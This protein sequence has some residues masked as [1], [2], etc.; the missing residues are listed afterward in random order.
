MKDKVLVLGSSGLIGHQVHS[1]LKKSGEYEL[2]DISCRNKIQDNTILLN[3]RDEQVFIDKITNIHPNYII[4]CIGILINASN[5]KP[6]DSIFLNAYMPHV[7]A[8]LADK[9]NA[10]LI[11]ISTDCVFSGFD[12]EP[13]IK[14][15]MQL[16]I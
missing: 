6:E 5:A 2:Y 14:T 10:K 3:A 13:L 8:R 12:F 4:N 11:H 7:L 16:I 9:M 15:P 1:Y